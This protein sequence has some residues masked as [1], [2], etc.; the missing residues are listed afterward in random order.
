MTRPIKTKKRARRSRAA[1]QVIR[2]ALFYLLNTEHPMTVRQVFYRMVGD[3]VVGKTEAEYKGTVCR[4]LTLMRREGLIPYS[5]LADNT[6]WMR[7]DHTFSGLKAALH[8]T[9]AAYRRSLWDNQN[10]YVEVWLEKD[11]L[12]G[13][14]HDITNSYDVPLMVCRGYS[15]LSFLYSAAEA[16]AEIGKPAHIYYF[17]DYDPSGVDISRVVEKELR[18]FAPD[19]EIHFNRM[20]VTSEQIATWNLPTRPTKKKDS[21]SKKFGANSVELDAIPPAIL[22]EMV[23]SCI[24]QHINTEAY[25]RMLIVE[26]AE[27]ESLEHV[28]S[29]WLRE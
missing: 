27:R 11:A 6:R 15:S 25:N 13:V 24:T 1:I 9:V 4:L 19:A 18:G 5:W 7:K 12:A 29:Q 23:T 3:G 20:A 8:Y 26:Q 21:R 16:I 2:D 17:G 10:A 28:V 14:V 22:R